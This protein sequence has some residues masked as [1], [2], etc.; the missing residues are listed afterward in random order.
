MGYKILKSLWVGFLL[1]FYFSVPAQGEITAKPGIFDHFQFDAPHAIVAGKEYRIILYAVDAFGNP[2]NMP[3]ESIK[4][5]KLSV[6]GSAQISPQNFK[7]KDIGQ[8]GLNIKIID[9][10]AEEVTVSLYEAN[11]PFPILE[12]KIKVLPD[13]I[14][15]LFIK[16]PQKVI[17]GNDFFVQILGK[18]RYGN[19]VCKEF[20][21]SLLNI[22]FKGDVSPQIKN[23]Q[24]VQETCSA[25]LRLYT[26]KMGSFYLEANI[27]NRNISGKSE[28]VKILNGNVAQFIVEAPLEAIVDEEFEI[29]ILAVDKF[30]NLVSNFSSQKER[31]KI[32]AQGKGYIFPAELSSYAFSNGIAR[33]GLKYDRPEEIKIAVKVLRENFIKGE[34]SSIKVNPPK[35]K[36]FEIVSPDTIIAEQKFKIKIIAY[37][38][39]DKIM[40]N[41]NLY[42]K[43]VILKSSG[44]GTLTPNRIPASAFVNGA[45]I[46]ELMYDKAEKFAIMASTEEEIIPSTEVKSKEEKK[47][48]EITRKKVSKAKKETKDKKRVITSKELLELKNISLVETKNSATLSIHIPNFEKKGGFQPRTKK[49]GKMM[50]ITVDIYPVANKIEK[51]LQFESDF[52]KEISISEEQNKIALNISLK[53][54]LKYRLSKKKDE[55]VIEFRRG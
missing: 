4:E 28:T 14:S 48:Q 36:R 54:P 17:V 15:S 31:V 44:T 24:Y 11:S 30:G 12:K 52:I 26:E 27:L 55:L 6:T 16:V 9:E 37:N 46:V 10:K 34:S 51:P 47:Y 45:A 35:I 33:V 25:T 21:P 42:G 2:V 19:I 29:R 49:L 1:L 7:A 22:F 39:F 5:Y 18:D 38:Q 41:Y 43:T 20:D 8:E 23:I 32:E 40:T 3:S 13:L 50:S 53:K